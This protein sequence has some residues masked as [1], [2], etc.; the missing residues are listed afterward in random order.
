MWALGC[1][2][3]YKRGISREA[4]SSRNSRMTYE[5]FVTTVSCIQRHQLGDRCVPMPALGMTHEAKKGVWAL[6][7]SVAHADS[8]RRVIP[9]YRRRLSRWMVVETRIAAGMPWNDGFSR[10]RFVRCPVVVSV[11]ID[12][13]RRGH[14]VASLPTQ[15]RVEGDRRI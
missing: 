13:R 6:R 7:R 1:R 11:F 10:H 4:V 3:R 14:A 2:T 9:R 8:V 12:S 15:L 5:A